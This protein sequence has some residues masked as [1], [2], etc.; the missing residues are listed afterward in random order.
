M[1]SELELTSS[2][3]FVES[4]LRKGKLILPYKDLIFRSYSENYVPK[5]IIIGQDPYYNGKIEFG[6]FV[7]Y[8]TGIAFECATEE[9]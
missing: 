3:K 5:V 9:K 8:S 7:P 2:I 4:E 1:V 6:R